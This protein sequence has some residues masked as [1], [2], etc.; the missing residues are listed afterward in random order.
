L[1]LGVGGGDNS[2]FYAVSSDLVHWSAPVLLF[3]PGALIGYGAWQP[4]DPLPVGYGDLIDPDSTALNFDVV[5]SDDSLYLYLIRMHTYVTS[6]GVLGLD[7]S[8]RDI[9]SYPL[10]FS[11]SSAQSAAAP[12]LSLAAGI[13]NQAQTITLSCSTPSSTIYYTTN[14]YGPALLTPYTTEYTKQVTVLN[15]QTIKAVCVAANYAISPVSSVRY[16]ITQ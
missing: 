1:F 11:Q 4:G 16:T 10:T 2:I 12:A 6:K 5:N 3:A 9:V 7:N 8:S 13:Y 14:G 15:S